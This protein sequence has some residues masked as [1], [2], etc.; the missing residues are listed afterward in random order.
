MGCIFCLY[1]FIYRRE[2]NHLVFNNWTPFLL[3]N[4][5]RAAL[6]TISFQLEINKKDIASSKSVA[7]S[8]YEVAKIF[9]VA[10]L[11]LRKVCKVDSATNIW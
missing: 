9:S 6:L 11:T 4:K 10:D 8:S 2:R 5:R 1:S 3:Q 7:L